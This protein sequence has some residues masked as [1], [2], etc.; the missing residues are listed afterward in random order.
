VITSALVSAK[1]EILWARV[2]SLIVADG[3]APFTPVEPGDK[4]RPT[5]KRYPLGRVLSG[6]LVER[7]G[8]GMGMCEE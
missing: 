8:A 5:T 1:S 2:Y 7:T 3:T 4:T 6:F